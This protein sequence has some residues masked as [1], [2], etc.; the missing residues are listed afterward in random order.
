VSLALVLALALLPQEGE[1]KTV[2]EPLQDAV[3]VPDRWRIPFPDYP[4]NE[5][6]RLYDPYRQNILKGDYPVLGQNIFAVITAKSDTTVETRRVPVP[7]GVSTVNGGSPSFFG[8]GDQQLFIQDL[9]GTIE[10]YKG[11]TAFRP[12]DWEVRVTGVMNWTYLEVQENGVVNPDV[13]EQTTRPDEHFALQEALAEYHLLDVG[14]HYDFVSVRAGI[15]PFV[16]DFRGF[17][18]SDTNLSARLFGTFASNRIQWNL[19]AFDQ[20]EKDT[21]SE[22]NT[23]HRREQQ[24]YVANMYVQDFLWLGYTAQVSF[25]MSRDDGDP[26]YDDNNFLVRP[27]PVGAVRKHD[28]DALYLGWAGDGHVGRWNVTHQLYHA[29]GRDEFNQFAGGQTDVSAWL[30]ALELSYDIDWIRL[31]GSFLWASGDRDADDDLATG[32]DSIF[33]APNF[34]G[35][36]FGFWNRQAVKLG[37]VNLVNRNSHLP[38][39]RTSKTQG[40]INFV[41]PGL[42][43]AGLGVDADVLPE[44]KA[45]FNANFLRF[46][47]TDVL[48]AYLQQ[49]DI[50]EEV[51]FDTSLGLVY[52]PFL[53]NNVILTLAGA[54]FLP[55]AGFADLYEERDTL[56]SAFAQLS[57]TY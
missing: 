36:T 41:N 49:P 5:P 7:S 28:V 20:L 34:A 51:G 38:D 56:F 3:P 13:T 31:K 35:G 46:H 50:D 29:F 33:E 22:L 52:R 30:A 47:Q 11:D 6:G 24:V 1:P 55:S 9:A 23:H 48:E 40:Q 42:F 16:S 53:N 25:H 10:I 44:L 45:A 2:G 57:L 12:R 18:F 8:D 39:L 4:L 14:E 21:N 15:Q 54:A 26:E 43:L 27:A 17:L 37:G 32:F 19:V